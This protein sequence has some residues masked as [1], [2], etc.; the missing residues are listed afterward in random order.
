M[1]TSTALILISILFIF[2]QNVSL[3]QQTENWLER[4]D[5]IP[6]RK[7]YLHTDRDIY[8][9][10]DSVW[11][12]AYYLDGQTHQFI[13]GFYS[14]YIDFFDKNGKT[15]IS[16]V[17][18][19]TD[20]V[21]EGNISIHDS[22]EPG[23]YLFRAFTDFQKS[24]GE[25]TFFHKTLKISKVQSS[26]E[27]TDD[28]S[29]KKQP[30]IDVAFLP[31]G[32]F[33]LA[34]QKNTVGLKAVD[35]NGKGISV[36]GKIMDSKGD[37]V[38]LF[39]T[40]YKGMDIIHF[41]PLA[42][43]IYKVRIEN[44]P[45][46]EYE[47]SHITKD[48]I[49]IEFIG[50]SKDNLLFRATTNS[51]LFQGEN[52]YFAIMHRGTVIFYKKFVQNKKDFQITV[53]QSALP[54]GI[55]R[56]ILLDETLK[57]ISERLYFSTNFDVNDV[58]IRLDQHTYETR[59]NVH[60]EIFDEDV[61]GDE[62]WS[63]LSVAVVD[64]KTIGENGP[65]LNIFS[66]LLIDSELKGY[67]ESPS[68]YFMD[69]ENIS[70]EDKLNLLMLTQGWSRYLWNT[71]PGK[72]IASDFNDTEGISINGRVEKILSNK[73]IINGDIVLKIYNNDKYIN[74]EGKTD[75]NGKFSFDSIF[76]TDTASVF[77]QARNNKGK[78]LTEVFLDSVFE[79]SPG[80]SKLYLPISKIS[81]G[82]PVKLYR[83]KY[84]NDLDLRNYILESG[85]IL[86]EEVT[87]VGEKR[88]KNDGHFRI[89]PKPRASL[90]VT[91]ADLSYR[92]IAD[93]LQG[94]VGGVLVMGDKIMIR[95]PGSFMPGGSTPLFLVNGFAVPEEIFLSIP[96]SDIDIVEVLK[97]IGEIGIFGSGGGNGV[98]SVFTKLEVD[99]GNIDTYSPGIIS[100]RIA[101]YSSFREFYSPI[102]TPE[103]IDSEKPDHRITL[104]WNP[105]I[106]TEHG[107]ASVSFF[108]SDDLSYFKVF[109][110]GITDNG[111]ICLGTAEFFVDKYL[112]N[113]GK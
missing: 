88:E 24:I 110:E 2:N 81:T 48:G 12:K 42:G 58:N 85:S 38:T 40:K 78:L 37:V 107:K 3:S 20:G 14:M 73:P 97:N 83:Q 35:E 33:L 7:L 36:Q 39:T 44:Y 93:Y 94:R 55:N 8:F 10:G 70:S 26:S 27:L 52:Y 11:F 56:F 60:L 72:S 96:M 71:I 6:Y 21:A 99:R 19:I 98:I 90:K 111:K 84:Y 62:S 41:N 34:G 29:T 64:E 46:Y 109:V 49:K 82:V 105:D 15:I 100:E 43:E 65:A 92:N 9:Q 103:N 28:N 61:M 4:N 23:N 80:V 50:E 16:R 86:L 22:L 95:G 101:G 57:P 112:I 67:I 68:D 59:S 32:G 25:E 89:Y 47:F 63:S 66:W 45:D 77:I 30:K 51:M 106:V 91:R 18:P 1:K 87:K 5:P 113:S 74:A 31:E 79:K 53:N 69:N 104:Y 76:F 54:G 75:K 102:Y 17:F 108:T 13:S